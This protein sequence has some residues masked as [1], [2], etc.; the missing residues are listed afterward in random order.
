MHVRFPSALKPWAILE[1]Y[2]AF[3]PEWAFAKPT[4]FLQA[5]VSIWHFLYRDATGKLP[6]HLLY[7]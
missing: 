2:H 7:R 6:N 1:K 4:V 3:L 5:V